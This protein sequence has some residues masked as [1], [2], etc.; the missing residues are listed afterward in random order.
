MMACAYWDCH[1]YEIGRLGVIYAGMGLQ[2]RP[3]AGAPE[4]TPLQGL[5]AH[6]LHF[7]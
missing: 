7:G 4:G 6:K 5:D 1:A 3:Q 2:T